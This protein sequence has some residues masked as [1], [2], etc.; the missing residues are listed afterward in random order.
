MTPADL[1]II[2][3]LDLMK[4]FL[5][6]S[7]LPSLH[8]VWPR[9]GAVVPLPSGQAA[10]GQQEGGR[11]GGEETGPGPG[12]QHCLPPADAATE[13]AAGESKAEH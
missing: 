3:S 1:I 10:G 5:L 9:A 4:Y 12:S 13:E 8:Y 2:L 6:P 7:S 11:G